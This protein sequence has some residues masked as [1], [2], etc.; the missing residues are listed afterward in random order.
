[1]KGTND[2]LQ[3]SR[4][5]V[6]ERLVLAHVASQAAAATD[7]P[8]PFGRDLLVYR[9]TRDLLRD[10]VARGLERFVDGGKSHER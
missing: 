9:E 8:D 5:D 10:W 6:I 3:P 2:V 4:G 7:V 1:M